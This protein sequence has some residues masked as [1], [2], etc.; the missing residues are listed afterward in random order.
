MRGQMSK[1]QDFSP[2]FVRTIESW[3]KT[4]ER[5]QEKQTNNE[6]QIWA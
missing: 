6:T 3:D 2:I 4:E 1:I 5:D